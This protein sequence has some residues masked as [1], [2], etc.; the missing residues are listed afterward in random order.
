MVML[1][2]PVVITVITRFQLQ[3]VNFLRASNCTMWPLYLTAA[4]SFIECFHNFQS[5]DTKSSEH[6]VL[7]ARN[8]SH[9]T[10]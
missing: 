1:A 10:W 2:H 9:L 8:Y 7:S 4:D 5:E 6:H 3:K